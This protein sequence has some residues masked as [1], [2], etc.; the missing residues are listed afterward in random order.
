MQS[1]KLAFI[2]KQR[3]ITMENSVYF[4]KGNGYKV[5]FLGETKHPDTRQWF[6]S[7]TYLQL[8]SGDIYTRELEDFEKRFTKV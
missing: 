1:V 8:N 7:V 2:W 3:E 5:L 4:Y 6:P